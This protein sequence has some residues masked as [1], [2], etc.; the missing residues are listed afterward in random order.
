MNIGRRIY[1]LRSAERLSRKCRDMEEPHCIEWTPLN[2]VKRTGFLEC[3][4]LILAHLRNVRTKNANLMIILYKGHASCWNSPRLLISIN[5]ISSIKQ[6]NPITRKE[7]VKISNT[8]KEVSELLA[9]KEGLLCSL[10]VD[11]LVEPSHYSL[12]EALRRCFESLFVYSTAH[13]RL[14]TT[15]MSVKLQQILC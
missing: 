6:M 13:C 14:A 1:D 5:W 9:R 10:C 7:H 8:A 12:S 15:H 4:R 11:W 3:K 2:S